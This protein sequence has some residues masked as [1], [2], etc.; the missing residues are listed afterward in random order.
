MN[1]TNIMNFVRTFEPR[2]SE[3]EKSSLTQRATG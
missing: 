1:I 2:D 3:V